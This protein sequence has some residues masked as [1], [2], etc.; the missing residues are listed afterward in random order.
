M[1]E[2]FN[3]SSYANYLLSETCQK[4]VCGVKLWFCTTWK[5][6]GFF[7][8][9]VMF[10]TLLRAIIE[11]SFEK[12][13]WKPQYSKKRRKICMLLAKKK[14][15]ICFSRLLQLHSCIKDY[16]RRYL[17]CTTLVCILLVRKKVTQLKIP[18]HEKKFTKDWRKVKKW[19]EG[20][21]VIFKY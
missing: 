9:W 14:K 12:L 7:D 5:G 4:F 13:A 6:L 3:N 21:T 2:H 1:K 17:C 11:N 20:R 19:G 15:K 18:P 8:I 16:F 10:H